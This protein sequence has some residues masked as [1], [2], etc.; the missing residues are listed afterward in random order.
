MTDDDI[1]KL[2]DELVKEFGDKLPNPEHF[3]I[4]FKYYIRLYLHLKELGSK[5]GN[6]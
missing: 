6:S 4:Q 5:N 1:V 3:P 2:Y